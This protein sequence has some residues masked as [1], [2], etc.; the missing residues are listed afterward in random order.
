MPIMP[1]SGI[2]KNLYDGDTMDLLYPEIQIVACMRSTLVGAPC[3]FAH[4]AHVHDVCSLSLP[5]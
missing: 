4:P 3:V 2:S 5:K 1:T